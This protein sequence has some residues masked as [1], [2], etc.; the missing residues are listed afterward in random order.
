MVGDGG[1]TIVFEPPLCVPG[2]DT[3]VA[4][5]PAAYDACVHLGLDVGVVDDV[6]VRAEVLPDLD[7]YT[8]WQS[9]WFSRLDDFLDAD[10]AFE[11]CTQLLKYAM[12]SLVTTCLLA[13]A[14]VESTQ[15]TRITYVGKEQSND[16]DPLLKGLPLQ[17]CLRRGDAP[18]WGQIL[19]AIASS[20]SIPMASSSS[21]G[22][23]TLPPENR[24]PIRQ[25]L[26]NRFGHLASPGRHFDVTR[27]RPGRT[28]STLLTWPGGYGSAAIAR[29]EHGRGRRILVLQRGAATTRMVEP[30]PWGWRAASD[31]VAV[32]PRPLDSAP[33]ALTELLA[34]FLSEIDTWC[35][36]PHV[37]DIFRSRLEAVVTRV[38]PIVD[39]AARVLAT[40]LARRHVSS[41]VSANPSSPEEFA[42]ILAARRSGVETV[43]AQHGDYM[44]AYEGWLVCETNLFTRLLTSDPTLLVDIPA[45]GE[46][47][48]IPTPT[49]SYSDHRRLARRRPKAGAVCYVPAFLWGDT[50]TIPPTTY[51]DTWYHRWH[52]GLLERML[53]H[54][55]TEFIWKALPD[56]DQVAD[57]IRALIESSQ[58]NVRYEIA[59]FRWLLDDVERTLVDV[60]STPAYEAAWAGIPLLVLAFPH[61]A[62]LRPHAVSQFQTVV[63]A[64]ADTATALAVLDEWLADD[65]SRWIVP[66]SALTV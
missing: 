3:V 40:D 8:R 48:G 4:V 24:P 14:L 26:L 31:P 64:C 12:D 28:E 23:Q 59:P 57:P 41:V 11:A 42:A 30:V 9:G 13:G 25:R 65:P 35:D 55:D 53:L 1:L 5:T 54:P 10:G 60:P 49:V 22:R 15:A 2:G 19:T 39:S 63:R 56:A 38:M 27:W 20:R 16:A 7:A 45:A 58:A 32:A 17:F 51:E 62:P 43:L 29:A 52:L 33:S 36:I 18:L 44:F 21:E 61:L 34:P 6:I 47:L 46:R 50:S 37:S 66:E